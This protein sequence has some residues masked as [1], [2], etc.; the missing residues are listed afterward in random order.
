MKKMFAGI[1]VMTLALIISAGYVMPETAFATDMKNPTA[2]NVNYVTE[3]GKKT[4]IKSF[5]I[6]VV[7]IQ[8]EGAHMMKLYTL[9][10]IIHIFL[11]HV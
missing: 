7:S 6:V 1:A 2:T 11:Q 10:R 4:G 9:L 8:M 5:T 3:N